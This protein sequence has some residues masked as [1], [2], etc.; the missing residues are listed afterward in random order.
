MGIELES[1]KKIEG[2][3]LQTNKQEAKLKNPH[4]PK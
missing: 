1:T 2:R 3:N 4:H